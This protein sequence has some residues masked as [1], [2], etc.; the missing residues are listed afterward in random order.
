MAD[1]TQ[2]IALDACC[3]IN[4][5]SA[6]PQILTL[7]SGQTARA[8]ALVDRPLG[9]IFHVC[10]RVA[11]DECLFTYRPAEEVD[12]LLQQAVDLAPLFK[13]GLIL[14]CELEAEAEMDLFVDLA[15]RVDDGEA[16]CLAI[17]KSRKWQVATDDRLAISVA[18]ELNVEVVSTPELVCHLAAVA[19]LSANQA[20][21]VI[22]SIE[23]L[24]RF[25]P[26]DSA[27]GAKW[28]NSTREGKHN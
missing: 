11:N 10:E 18:R 13:S 1:F 4:L 5:L 22:Q 8:G 3:L 16:E 14:Q 6:E 12:E 9:G 15:S 7:P 19:A 17:A 2:P 21:S 25:I 24:A 23:K 27:A 20:K 26:S 28:W